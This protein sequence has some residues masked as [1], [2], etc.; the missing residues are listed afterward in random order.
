MKDQQLL[1]RV[2]D[3]LLKYGHAEHEHD[4]FRL[5]VIAGNTHSWH[6]SPAVYQHGYAAERLRLEAFG[7][8]RVTPLDSFVEPGLSVEEL[9]RLVCRA[10]KAQREISPPD[11]QRELDKVLQALVNPK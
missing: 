7:H 8:D 2:H 10:I 3:T 5:R 11:I 1:M 9:V 4:L 6:T